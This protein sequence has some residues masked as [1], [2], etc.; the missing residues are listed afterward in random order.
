MA[1]IT[2]SGTKSQN[3]SSGGFSQQI[4]NPNNWGSSEMAAYASAV[5]MLPV[6]IV[7]STVTYTAYVPQSALLCRISAALTAAFN[8]SATVEIGSSGPLATPSAPVITNVGTAGSTTYTYEVVALNADGTH[9]AASAAGSTTT[10]NATLS[11]T[12]YNVVTLTA[13]TGAASYNVYRTV[14]GATQGLLANVTALTLNDTNLT[15]DGSTAPSTANAGQDLMAPVSLAAGG[16]YAT[17]LAPSVA[18]VQTQAGQPVGV[19]QVVLTVTGSPTAGAG[20]ILLE[21][22]NQ[23]TQP[24]QN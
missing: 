6:A 11:G 22:I 18:L 3:V 4:Q 10:G 23:L 12:A 2:T 20:S 8:N 24:L 15:G 17:L 13:V 1:S 7:H 9:S 5:Q 21:Y 19:Q 14:G 16:T